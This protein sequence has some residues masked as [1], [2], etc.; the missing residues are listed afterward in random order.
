MFV[1]SLENCERNYYAEEI[2]VQRGGWRTY[3]TGH[4]SS[5]FGPI[6]VQCLI[7]VAH[8]EFQSRPFRCKNSIQSVIQSKTINYHS[9][10]QKQT[11][12]CYVK[13]HR[14]E[15]LS[16]TAYRMIL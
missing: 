5:L 9:N 13:Q 12:K 6:C 14:K 7:V 3:S 16:K 2:K 8:A 1:P 10:K 15:Y 4:K 11:A